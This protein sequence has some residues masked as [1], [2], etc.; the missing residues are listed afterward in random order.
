MASGFVHEVQTLIALGRSYPHIHQ[1][2]DEAAQCRPGLAHRGVRHHWYQAHG[3]KWDLDNPNS[4]AALK[5]LNRVRRVLGPDKAD[6]YIASMA[7][8]HLDVVWDYAELSPPE[9]RFIRK[10]WEAFHVWIVLRPE[11][12]KTWGGVDVLSARIHRVIDGV[13]IWE[14]D[15]NVKHEYRRLLR[16]AHILVRCDPDIA[17]MLKQYGQDSANST[18]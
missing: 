6:E 9:R 14:V 13:E 11:V 17:F 12:L 3:R 8:D 15:P 7:H 10:Y 1:R 16:R 2:K 5:R 4:D 18:V